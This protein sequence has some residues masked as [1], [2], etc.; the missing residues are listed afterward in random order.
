MKKRLR[1]WAWQNFQQAWETWFYNRLLPTF[2]VHWFPYWTPLVTSE[3][4]VQQASQ[5]VADLGEIER[6]RTR[7]NVRVVEGAEVLPVI[8]TR[9]AAPWAPWLGPTWVSQKQM[10]NDLIWAGVAFTKTNQQPNHILLQLWRQLWDDQK[11][12]NSSKRS[13]VRII[14]QVPTRTW[15]LEDFIVPIRRKK[16]SLGDLSYDAWV[17]WRKGPGHRTV[18]GVTEDVSSPVTRASRWD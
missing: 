11:F 6:L 4:I 12:Q 2:M 10:F 17:T 8:K 9:K 16:A 7:C 3:A 1:A 5:L 14:W 15:N 18:Y 13:G